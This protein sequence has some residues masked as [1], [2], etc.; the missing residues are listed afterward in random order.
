M[1]LPI[2][3]QLPTKHDIAHHLNAMLQQLSALFPQEMINSTMIFILK[4][5]KLAETQVLNI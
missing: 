5:W 1:I 3:I 4:T 2:E